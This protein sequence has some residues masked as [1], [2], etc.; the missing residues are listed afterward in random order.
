MTNLTSELNDYVTT[1]VQTT[2][3]R[4]DDITNISAVAPG[5]LRTAAL[6]HLSNGT[7]LDLHREDIILSSGMEIHKHRVKDK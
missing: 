3:A 6:N 1:A 4:I 5:P 2:C 7:Q